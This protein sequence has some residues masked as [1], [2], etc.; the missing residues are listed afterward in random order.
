LK[1]RQARGEKKGVGKKATNHKGL[2]DG[3]YLFAAR[4]MGGGW[5]KRNADKL[6]HKE[7]K[8]EGRN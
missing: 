2:A 8:G 1:F 4:Y 7:G 5:E 3:G 6:G